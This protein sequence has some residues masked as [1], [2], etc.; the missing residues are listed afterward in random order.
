MTTCKVIF[1]CLKVNYLSIN[2][3][4]T[5][6]QSYTAGLHFYKRTFVKILESVHAIGEIPFKN[7]KESMRTNTIFL[8]FIVNE[9]S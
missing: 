1:H 3:W 4:L 6:D 7:T 2:Q 5:I 9:T 8:I